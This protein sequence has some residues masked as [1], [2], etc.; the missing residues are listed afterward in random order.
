MKQT[1]LS[2][3]HHVF[4]QSINN[5]LTKLLHTHYFFNICIVT[6]KQFRYTISEI[7]KTDK[8]K[9]ICRQN[10]TGVSIQRKYELKVISPI[11]KC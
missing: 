3:T 1:G 8:D 7:I 4:V 2:L 9:N 5:K 11:G 6:H 10:K